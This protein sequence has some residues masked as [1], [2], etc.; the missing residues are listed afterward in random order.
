MNLV[1]KKMQICALK[2]A[3]LAH[4]L[5]CTCRNVPASRLF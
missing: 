3:A 2:T 5:E 4:G 1:R